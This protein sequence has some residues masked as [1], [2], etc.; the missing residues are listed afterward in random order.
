[1][2]GLEVIMSSEISQAQKVKSGMISAKQKLKTLTSWKLGVDWWF[3]EAG[4]DGGEAQTGR[5]WPIGTQLQ[6]DNVQ[7]PGCQVLT[8]IIPAV[9]KA[10]IRRIVVRSQSGQ[11]V[12][13]TLSETNS[14]NSTKQG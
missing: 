8:P 9:Q 10:E 13:K 3:P 14:Q 1:M 2:N 7:G 11:T 12:P 6:L 4:V 5:S